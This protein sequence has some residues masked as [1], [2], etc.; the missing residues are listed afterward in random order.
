PRELIE[1]GDVVVPLRCDEDVTER[2][3][4]SRAL[5]HL[6][7]AVAEAAGL[8][9]NDARSRILV[10]VRSGVLL[11][12][13]V[14][15]A[16]AH[17]PVVGHAFVRR[18][19]DAVIRLGVIRPSRQDAVNRSGNARL[20]LVVRRGRKTGRSTVRWLRRT[21]V[22]ADGA[23]GNVIG[24]RVPVA[25][26]LRLLVTGPEEVGVFAIRVVDADGEVAH[27]LTLAADDE[28]IG[29]RRLHV[30]VR[31][32]RGARRSRI[33]RIDVDRVVVIEQLVALNDLV[34]VHFTGAVA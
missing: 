20:E 9:G 16:A 7:V 27:Q 5:E 33:R 6:A 13:V 24:R 2:A 28:L 25:R 10:A 3:G 11:P 19:L 30:V 29:L 4:A 1:A 14:R 15:E 22:S 23:G 12:V 32:N 34:F 17:H 26:A 31:T 18:E 8:R 21:R